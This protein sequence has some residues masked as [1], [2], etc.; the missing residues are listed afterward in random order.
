MLPFVYFSTE[1]LSSSTEDQMEFNNYVTSVF[2]ENIELYSAFLRIADDR[3]L[4]II[5]S[6]F[7][8]I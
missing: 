5:Y 4:Q 6:H 7:E 1:E 3:K 8:T 2:L